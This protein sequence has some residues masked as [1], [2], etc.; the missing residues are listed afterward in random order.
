MIADDLTIAQVMVLLE[1]GIVQGF[2]RG[3]SHWLEF[4]G[5]QIAQFIV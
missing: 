5:S 2:E 3:I 1:Q 4:N